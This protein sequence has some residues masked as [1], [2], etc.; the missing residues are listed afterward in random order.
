MLEYLDHSGPGSIL[1]AHR[2]LAGEKPP[3]DVH[4]SRENLAVL[5][6]GHFVEL[7]APHGLFGPVSRNR[8]D[9]LP[10]CLP[11]RTHE[12]GIPAE[13]ALLPGRASSLP[14]S[15][16]RAGSDERL[17]HR[18]K[19]RGEADGIAVV[20]RKKPSSTDVHRDPVVLRVSG[21]VDPLDVRVR[22][23]VR[24]ALVRVLPRD[25][26]SIRHPG[27]C[28]GLA[29]IVWIEVFDHGSPLKQRGSTVAPAPR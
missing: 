14:T 7:V 15:R 17:F 6:V 20:D 12:V 8:H 23:V 21:P 9:G 2:R 19:L 22:V 3:S 1:H 27:G 25:D 4:G 10:G 11:C 13:R 26:G 29:P 18:S 5:V 16:S 24:R 28:E